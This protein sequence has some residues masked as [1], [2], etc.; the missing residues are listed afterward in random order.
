MRQ[1][2]EEELAWR[3]QWSEEFLDSRKKSVGLSKAVGGA[4]RGQG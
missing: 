1:E 3:D 4:G 2:D